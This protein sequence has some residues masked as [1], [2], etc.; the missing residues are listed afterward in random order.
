M[1]NFKKFQNISIIRNLKIGIEIN[2][3]TEWLKEKNKRFKYKFY[4][5]SIEI[6]NNN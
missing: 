2:K 4:K 5:I 3:K 6:F 1:E